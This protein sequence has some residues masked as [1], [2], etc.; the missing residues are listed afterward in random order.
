MNDFVAKPVDPDLLYT[1]LLKWLP[2]RRTAD[3]GKAP[4]A[5]V[6]ASEAFSLAPEEATAEEAVARLA[7]LPGFNLDRGLVVVRGNIG[8][9]LK[10]IQL[11]VN[12]H[13]ADM[14]GLEALL[15]DGDLVAA[16]RLAHSLKGAAAAIGAEQLRAMA[17][18]LESQL[19]GRREGKGAAGELRDLIDA[20]SA[21]LSVLAAAQG[22]K[23]T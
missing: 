9:Y 10:L 6:P 4:E 12:A 22:H 14:I 16:E 7:A 11:F 8:K 17:K 20:I 19:A 5:P 21:E 2:P 1:V 13:A 15:A 18:S 3:S 23:L